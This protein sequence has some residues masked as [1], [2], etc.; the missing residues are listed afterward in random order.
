MVD[1]AGVEP[2]TYRFKVC[3]S[4]QLSYTSKDKMA[5]EL[6]FEPRLATSEA[7]V[8]PVELFPIGVARRVELL[9]RGH[10][11]ESIPMVRHNIPL[12][13]KAKL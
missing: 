12:P 7:A 6:G 3:R 8:L 1:A 10:N 2:T 13:R 5:G 4:S 11:P 9:F